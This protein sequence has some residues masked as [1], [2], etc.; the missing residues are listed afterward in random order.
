MKAILKRSPKASRYGLKVQY[1]VLADGE[2]ELWVTDRDGL[3]QYEMRSTTPEQAFARFYSWLKSYGEGHT[4]LPEPEP[5]QLELQPADIRDLILSLE[6]LIMRVD[7]LLDRADAIFSHA[8][9][10]LR[11]LS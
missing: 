8:D 9:R 5:V 7:A 4:A 2:C 10:V 6:R 11:E 1:R 3:V